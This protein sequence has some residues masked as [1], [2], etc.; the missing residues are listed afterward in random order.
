MIDIITKLITM[1]AKHGFILMDDEGRRLR[2]RQ[3]VGEQT[4]D[5]IADIHEAKQ[6]ILL[7]FGL[8]HING[9]PKYFVIDSVDAAQSPVLDVSLMRLAL[10]KECSP[11]ARPQQP[12]SDLLK[13]LSGL[14][15]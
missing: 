10:P 11:T 1:C 2:F 7:F 15:V 6:F 13:T 3:T 5:I 12:G 4:K 14:K 8:E 9:V